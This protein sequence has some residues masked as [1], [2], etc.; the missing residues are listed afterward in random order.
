MG[1]G[2]ESGGGINLTGMG[3]KASGFKRKWVGNEVDSIRVLN[4]RERL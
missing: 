4:L 3:L 1:L 2:L